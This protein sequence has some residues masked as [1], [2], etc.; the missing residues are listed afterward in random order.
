M[1]ETRPAT[2]EP[3]EEF[4]VSRVEK[5]AVPTSGDRL[6]FVLAG[7][8]IRLT[9]LWTTVVEF[10]RWI[11][12]T[13][14]DVQPDADAP[15]LRIHVEP[16]GGAELI[17]PP[18]AG[19][20]FRADAWRP[21]WRFLSSLG[22][23]R[24]E[25]D[26]R[27]ESNQVVDV[28]VML[29]ACRRDL[30][31]GRAESRPARMLRGERG[32]VHACA[33]T[34][35]DDGRLTVR[36]TYCTTRLSGLVAWFERRQ[37]RLQDHRA[38]YRAAPRYALLF[39][40]IIVASFVIYSLYDSFW[41]H[42]V[43]TT[44]GAGIL[45][46][47]TYL[48]FLTIGGLEYDNEEKNH[49]LERAYAEVQRY[50]ERVRHDLSRARTV[51]Q[52]L[53]PDSG[54]MPR[55]DRLEWAMS[56]IPESE[57]GGDY[58]DVS[59]LPDGRVAVLFTD[60]SGHGMSAALVTAIIKT[61]FTRY[62]SEGGDEIGFMRELNLRLCEMTPDDSFAAAVLMVLN[63]SDGRLVYVNCG[64]NPE[65]LR[66]AAG[67]GEVDTLRDSRGR[68][69]GVLDEL[70]ADA[71]HY[72]LRAGDTLLL[73]TDGIVEAVNGDRAQYGKERLEQFLAACPDRSPQR[74]VE[75]LEEE[76]RSFIGGARQTDDR[77]MLAVRLRPDAA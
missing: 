6:R 8:R 23:C 48:F 44:V 53:L 49:R 45:F 5:R 27:L 43:V 22:L 30:A 65:P 66:I 32:L 13:G 40:G 47:L 55:T 71:S 75:E 36:Y 15:S 76:M 35:V 4:Q 21:L 72:A 52:R 60:V 51:Q 28:L 10:A 57:V 24:I 67:S 3:A 33:E 50:T 1:S 37:R 59:E 20:S 25:L 18:E 46:G 58:F 19:E 17:G 62:A 77:T 2:S 34:R 7:A 16:D 26:P 54:D 64:H 63:P 56:F 70:D 29:Y 41:F 14:R 69:L 9:K 74:L 11:E 68:L 12:R 61:V 39:A 73:V 38:L 42:V 31:A